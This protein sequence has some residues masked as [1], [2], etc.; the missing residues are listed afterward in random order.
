MFCRLIG[1]KCRLLSTIIASANAT[2][3][4]AAQ[5]TTN[6]FGAF[7]K[8][9]CELLDD[10]MKLNA[11][12]Y[13]VN[14]SDVNA[15]PLIS[16]LVSLELASGAEMKKA[17]RR[18]CIQ[19]FARCVNDTGSP[20]VQIGIAT[21]RM[22]VLDRHLREGHHHDFTTERTRTRIMHERK[23]MLKYLKR[24][25]LDRFYACLDKIGEPPEYL[26]SLER[27]YPFK[28]KG[29]F[30]PIKI[31]NNRTIRSPLLERCVQNLQNSAV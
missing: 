27:K 23:N 9:I 3:V 12:A 2:S 15:S 24:V 22:E 8:K 28:Y 10:P 13:N 6:D 7:K 4:N 26:E 31:P 21:M 17:L 19:Y 5:T 18:F 20:E 30:K 11:Y 29:E 25:S 14:P 16:R 1:R